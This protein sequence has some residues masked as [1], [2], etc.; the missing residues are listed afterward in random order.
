MASR[1]RLT[2]NERLV[3]A[4]IPEAQRP[5]VLAVLRSDY[6][7][8]L[9]R[10]VHDDPWPVVLDARGVLRWKADPM[11]AALTFGFAGAP[12]PLDLN[13]LSVALQSGQYA[14]ADYRRLAK[15]MHYS[16]QGYYELSA[17][18]TWLDDARERR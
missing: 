4:E 5:R 10:D 6:P 17:I 2:R 13:R 7:A 14:P 11:V 12:P 9:E 15:R 18:Q 3:L 16:L 1:P 8:V